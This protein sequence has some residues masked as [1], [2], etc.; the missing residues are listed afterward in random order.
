MGLTVPDGS[1][2]VDTLI[3]PIGLGAN[4]PPVVGPVVGGS[5]NV[6]YAEQAAPV[7]LDGSI[8]VSDADSPTLVGAT[9]TIG[10]RFE[11]GDTLHFVDQ[12]GIVGTYDPAAHVLTLTGTATVAQY[13]SA[14]QWVTFD[15]PTSDNPTASGASPLRVIRWQVDDGIDRSNIYQTFVD[16]T[17]VNEAPVNHVP[18]PQ[19]AIAGTDHVIGGLSVSDVDAGDGSLTTLLA[20]AHGTLTVG[21]AGGALVSGSGTG[22]VALTGTVAEIN[23]TLAAADNIVYRGDS[24]F[25]T[26]T[27]TMQTDDGGHTG[28]P[29][30]DT[31]TVAIDLSHALPLLPHNGGRF[32][33]DHGAGRA[34]RDHAGVFLID[35]VNGSQVITHTLGAVGDEW[36][37]LGTGYFNGDGTSDLLSQRDSDGMLITHSISN[38]QVTGATL[39]GAIG[40]DFSFRGIG[41]FNHD[42][43]SDLLWQRS[44]DG[45]LIV[46][47]VQNNQIVGTSALGAI[48]TDWA[49]LGTGDFNNDGTSDLLWQH[50]SD[51]MLLIHDIQNNRV[52]GIALVGAIGSDWHFAG[53]GDFNGDHTSDLLFQREDGTL[54]VYSMANNQVVAS[55]VLETLANDTHVVGI[56]DYTGDG[57]DDLLLSHDGGGLEL[58]RIEANMIVQS[59]RLDPIG[60][61]L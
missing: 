47:N 25:S 27:L 14:L 39:L 52:A 49:F 21:S 59:I 29:L 38:N 20:V 58:Q 55:R 44:S 61:I 12:S 6:N 45:L 18:G 56:A 30:S 53:S 1:L 48:G 60:H 28:D 41:D 35:D 4:N 33:A 19:R 11:S 34:L 13:Q 24:G 36:R 17:P 43:S 22:L 31:D 40:T 3:G 10:S 7:V 46:H 50:A 57:T 5:I 51:G 23:A 16:V 8:P 37:F 42:G 54:R 9:V 26:D 32:D 15:N 2:A